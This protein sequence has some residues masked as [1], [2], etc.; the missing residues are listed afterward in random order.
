MSRRPPTQTPSTSGRHSGKRSR[1][2]SSPRARRRRS[3]RS[4]KPP[5]TSSPP[6]S[7]P[8]RRG[9]ELPEPR[10]P[11]PPARARR[12]FRFHDLRHT[13]ASRLASSGV[14]MQLIV[15]A[16]AHT[17]IR[18]CERYARPSEEALRVVRDAL[19]R[20]AVG[21]LGVHRLGAKPTLQG[22]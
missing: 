12:R 7:R 21:G 18:T 22:A 3:G 5:S 20:D 1:A 19:D 14:P 6:A 4:S 16:F 8:R 13:S 10:R 17:S 2:G 11:P 9:G 15:R